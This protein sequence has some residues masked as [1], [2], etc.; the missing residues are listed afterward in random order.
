MAGACM[1]RG[2][3][4]GGMHGGGGVVCMAGGCAC[5]GGGCM[6]GKACVEM[7]FEDGSGLSDFS[8]TQC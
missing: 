7:E 3:W 2:E 4:P 1:A 5:R 8:K 6:A